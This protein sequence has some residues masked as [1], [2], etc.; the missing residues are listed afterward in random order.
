MDFA[1]AFK[2]PMTGGGAF[3]LSPVLN[4]IHPELTVKLVED[5]RVQSGKATVKD[6]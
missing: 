6:V 1:P 5:V 2:I 3:L 4:D